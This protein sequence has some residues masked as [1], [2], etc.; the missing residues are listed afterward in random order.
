MDDQDKAASPFLRQLVRY[1]IVGLINTA[2][3]YALYAALVL[4]GVPHAWALVADYAAGI[5]LGFWLNR[6][7]TFEHRAPWQPALA[8]LIAMYVPLLALNEVLLYLLVDVGHADKLLAQLFA[9]LVVAVLSFLAQ[10]M[11]VF[12]EVSASRG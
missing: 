7:Y 9:L 8:K 5:A 3:T 11:I 6:R 10:K 1:H 4:A 2:A 12:R